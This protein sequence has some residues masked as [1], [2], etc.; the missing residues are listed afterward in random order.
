MRSAF[1]SARSTE[2]TNVKAEN[3]STEIVHYESQ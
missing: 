3:D 2:T 1:E